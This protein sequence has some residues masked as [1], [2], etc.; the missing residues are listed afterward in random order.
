MLQSNVV[1][2]NDVRDLVSVYPDEMLSSA[3]AGVSITHIV[4]TVPL[5]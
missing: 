3:C 2:L 4:I 1:I 5:H